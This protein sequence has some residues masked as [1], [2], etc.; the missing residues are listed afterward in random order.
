MLHAN[1][2]VKDVILIVVSLVLAFMMFFAGIF[3]S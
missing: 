2:H 3:P 1:Q